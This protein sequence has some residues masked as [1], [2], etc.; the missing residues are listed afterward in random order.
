MIMSVRVVSDEDDD[1]GDDQEKRREREKKR[2]DDEEKPQNYAKQMRSVVFSFLVLSSF[3]CSP[4]RT[5][6]HSR[7]L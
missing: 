7:P 1:D 5:R 2:D 4:A 3:S 6:T